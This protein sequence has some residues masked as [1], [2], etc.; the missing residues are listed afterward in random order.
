MP[1]CGGSRGPAAGRESA[2]DS[3]DDASLDRRASG[4]ESSVILRNRCWKC[5][6]FS[7]MS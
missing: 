7:I 3:R 6:V 1:S 5:L 2:A 4:E